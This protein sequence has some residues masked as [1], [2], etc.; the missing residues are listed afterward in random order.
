MSFAGPYGVYHSMYDD[1]YWM[2]HFG[3]PGFRYMT[4]M[5][6]VWGRMALRL[7]N[8]DVYPFDFALYASRLG[9][10]IDALG[11]QPDV[12]ARVDLGAVRGAQRRWLA[13]AATMESAMRTA[14][15]ARASLL[16][17]MNDALRGVEQQLLFADGIPGR[18]WFRHALY[19]P[20]PSYAAMT[21][22]GIQEAIDAKDWTRARAQAAA[23]ATRIEGAAKMVEQAAA[24]APH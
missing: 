4:T 5:S 16:N 7:A 20:R 12:T 18:P 23:L 9:G 10:F 22:P 14:P 6:D 11:K 13:A 17:S 8:A 15:G 1:Y 24:L 3:D 2:T 21:L 19:A